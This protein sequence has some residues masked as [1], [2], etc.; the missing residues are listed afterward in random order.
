MKFTCE[1][2][3]ILYAHNNNGAAIALQYGDEVWLK[4]DLPNMDLW[5]KEKWLREYPNGWVRGVICDITPAGRKIKFEI[6]ISSYFLL[7]Q[8]DILAV[9]DKN[10][11]EA[12]K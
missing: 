3:T 11:E 9:S 7:T 4:L 12:T 6:G 8:K 1:T 5:N 2:T 10:P